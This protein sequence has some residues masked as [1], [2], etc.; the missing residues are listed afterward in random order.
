MPIFYDLAKYSLM[1]T[2][3]KHLYMFGSKVYISHFQ[4]K[5]V[6]RVSELA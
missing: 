4:T 6:N 1:L 5:F 3:N 2:L